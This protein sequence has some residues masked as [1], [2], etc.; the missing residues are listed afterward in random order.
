SPT[1]RRPDRSDGWARASRIRTR[2][3]RYRPPS[4]PSRPPSSSRGRARTAGSGPLLVQAFGSDPLVELAE[5]GVLGEVADRDL[6]ADPARQ[7]DGIGQTDPV[8]AVAAGGE[9]FLLAAH[10][11]REVAQHLDMLL[12]PDRAVVL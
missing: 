2:R 8:D 9:Q 1:A 10:G 3:A 11:R 4:S 7:L 6:L 12:A 5:V